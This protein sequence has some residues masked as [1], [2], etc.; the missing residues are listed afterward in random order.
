M[1]LVLIPSSDFDGWTQPDSSNIHEKFTNIDEMSDIPTIG[2][3]P[4]TADLM[5]AIAKADR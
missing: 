2:S 3:D 1:S 4:D 5:S